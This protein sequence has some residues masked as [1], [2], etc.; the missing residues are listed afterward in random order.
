MIL[1]HVTYVTDPE[2][3]PDPLGFLLEVLGRPGNLLLLVV[4]AAVVLLAGL[5]WPRRRP[6]LAPW[7][8]FVAQAWSYRDFVPWML[9]LSF[10]LVLIGSGLT[11]VVFAPDVRLGGWPDLLLTVLGFLLLLGL[12][13]RLAALVGLVLYAVALAAQPQLVGLFD[14]AGGLAAIAFLGPGVP[15]LDDLLRATFPSGPGAV[16]ATR[17]PSRQRYEDL[18]PL[19]VRIGLGGALLASG[20]VD[21]LLVYE[22]G[23]A[24]VDKYGLTAL[25]P[26]DPGLWVVGAALVETA[27]GAAILLGLATRLSAM[28]GF[29][30]LT[31]TLFGLPDDPVIAHVG[32]FGSCSVL[33]VL[34]AGRWSLDALLARADRAPVSSPSLSGAAAAATGPGSRAARRR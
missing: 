17:Q 9:R 6:M 5:A 25:V 21:K 34:G 4:G 26:V 20:I 2:A 19:L 1:A 28:L 31:L 12:A 3:S 33:V 11:R 22:R 32:L 30:V 15:S 14:L 13:V 27:L 10:G 24:T 29:A 23:L 8:R 18:V 16:A 7:E